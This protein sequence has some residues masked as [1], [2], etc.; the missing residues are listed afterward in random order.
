VAAYQVVPVKAFN[1]NYIWT[2][3]DEH[4]AAVVDA[5]D[6]APVL[7]YLTAEKLEL[8]AILSTHHHNDHVGGNAE[9]LNHFKVPVYGPRDERIDNVT[10]RLRE[11]ER[12]SLPHFNIEFEV[13]DCPAHTRTHIAFVGD[14]MLYCGD[15]MFAAGC[16][17]LFEGTPAQMHEALT[18][19]M[20][21]PDNTRVYCG[22]E[23]TVANMRFAKTADPGNKALIELEARAQKLRA[24]NLPTL[25]SDIAQEKATNP[26]VRCTEAGVIAAA[27]KYAGKALT[28]AVSVLGALREWKNN[29]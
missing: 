19:F 9:L 27:S 16:G 21:L 28:D 7:A 4:R 3:R 12:F 26:F 22:H 2:I 15:T 11:G 25:P 1:D 13:I 20:R 5:G 18:K 14:G 10:H 6:A 23:Y 17:R 8:V 29:S 24:A